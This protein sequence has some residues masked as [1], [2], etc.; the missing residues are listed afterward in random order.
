MFF[1]IHFKHF[2]LLI[3]VSIFLLHLLVLLFCFLFLLFFCLVLF[4]ILLSVF[5]FTNKSLYF[6]NF[7]IFIIT[8]FC[9]TCINSNK[10]GTKFFSNASCLFFSKIGSLPSWFCSSISMAKIYSVKETSI[11]NNMYSQPFL[12][13]F[14]F[15]L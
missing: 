12:S 13:T 9:I 5:K 4:V 15:S 11:L 7:I 14:I 10:L 8:S 2:H 1:T 6:T 3:K